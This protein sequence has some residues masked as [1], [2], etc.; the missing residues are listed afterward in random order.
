ML[1]YGWKECNISAYIYKDEMKN[2]F[3][4]LVI[5][6]LYTMYKKELFIPEKEWI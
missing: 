1:D 5:V 4:H 6:I 2:V 3:I